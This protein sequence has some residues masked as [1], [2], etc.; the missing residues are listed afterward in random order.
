METLI[1][2]I[3]TMTNE[4]DLVAA[5]WNTNELLALSITKDIGTPIVPSS[6]CHVHGRNP[7]NSL[8][9]ATSPSNPN[10]IPAGRK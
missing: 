9:H 5:L 1:R 6:Y 3:Y 10:P 2:K 8:P 4:S 7:P